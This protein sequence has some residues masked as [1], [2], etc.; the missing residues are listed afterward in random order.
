MKDK[1][2]LRLVVDVVY[3]LG[4]TEVKELERVLQGAVQHLASEGYLTGLDND[5]RVVQWDSSVQPVFGVKG[6]QQACG[7][8]NRFKVD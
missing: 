6:V 4:T 3:G 2:H 5:A 1:A 8:V 7:A